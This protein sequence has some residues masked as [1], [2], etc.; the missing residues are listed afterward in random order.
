MSYD[1]RQRAGCSLTEERLRSSPSS[2]LIEPVGFTHPCLVTSSSFYAK[3]SV[4]KQNAERIHL[5]Y[6]K[7]KCSG[8]SQT[9]LF[10]LKYFLLVCL[11]R[12]IQEIS[13]DVIRVSIQAEEGISYLF[14]LFRTAHFVL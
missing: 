4:S 5:K 7:I 12:A 11:G 1:V 2:C 8:I 9:F 6:D 3:K 14:A 13:S 10:Y